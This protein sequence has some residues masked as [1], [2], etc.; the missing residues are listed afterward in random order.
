MHVHTRTV[1]IES[2]RCDRNVEC[3]KNRYNE[4]LIDLV[5]LTANTDA[6]QAGGLQFAIKNDVYTKISVTNHMRDLVMRKQ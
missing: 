1:N 6:A 5:V 4:Y 2:L 3:S